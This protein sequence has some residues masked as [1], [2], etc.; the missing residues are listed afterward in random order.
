MIKNGRPYS[1]SREGYEDTGLVSD[2]RYVEKTSVKSSGGMI[3][4]YQN[5]R[6]YSCCTALCRVG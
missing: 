4:D 1:I 3:L 2:F 5:D 6:L